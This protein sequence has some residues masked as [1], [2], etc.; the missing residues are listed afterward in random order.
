MTSLANQLQSIA[1]L[2]ASRLTSRY[3]APTSKSYL[4]P[5]KVAASHDL[6]AIFSLAQSGFEELRILDPEMEE[7][8]D[9]LF[10]EAAKRMDR[11]MLNKAQNEQLDEILGRC[12]R[13]LGMWVGLMAG[14]KCIEWL[15]RR[16]RS[17]RCFGR[18]SSFADYLPSVHEMNAETVLQVFL[19]YHQSP[20]FPRILS[21]LSLPKSS[22]YHAPFA[23]LVKTAQTIPRS[24][25]ITAISPERDC[26][27]RLL[28]DVAGMIKIA[29]DEKVVHRALLAFWTST[30][31]ELL[32]RARMGKGVNEGVVKVLVEAFVTILST[33]GGGQDVNVG[34]NFL[35][36]RVFAHSSRPASILL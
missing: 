1:S 25:I 6:D 31:V 26:S 28:S 32:E 34:V 12:L 10:S 13:R 19:P 27:L 20:N 23:P 36:T 29:L 17:V 8:E 33:P 5:P 35:A 30:M 18:R 9:E 2:D 21:I 11:M 4:F 15:V 7:Y 14:G 24:Y 16:F 3:G 22:K